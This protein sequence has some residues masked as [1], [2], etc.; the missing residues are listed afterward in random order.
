MPSLMKECPDCSTV[1]HVRKLGC[2]C[3]H[4]FGK[5]KSLTVKCAS[6]QTKQRIIANAASQA[7]KRALETKEESK[8]RKKSNAAR[9]ALKIA[10]ETQQEAKQLA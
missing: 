2:P 8:Q 4:I 9:L 3:G 7:R 6:K 5:S 1:V 10:L